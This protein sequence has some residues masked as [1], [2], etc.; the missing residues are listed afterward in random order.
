MNRFTSRSG[1][2]AWT[3]LVLVSALSMFAFGPANAQSVGDKT[4]A[5]I[6]VTASRLEQAQTD[7]L[8]HT[9]VISSEDIKN[10]GVRDLPSLLQ[11]EAGI[12]FTQPGG[13][14]QPASLFMRGATPGETLILIDGVPVRREGFSAA[15]ALEHILPDQIDR[16]EIVRGNV[17]A[18]YGS[19]AIGG[20][21]QIFTKQGAGTPTAS[22]SAEIGSRG[23]R[24]VTGG[25]SG[26]SGNTRYALSATSFRTD[27]VSANNT[28]QYPNENPDDDGY[29]NKS[30]AASLSNEWTKG[31][32]LG[33]RLY[34]N[35]GKFEYDGGGFGQ[36]T[37]IDT[38]RSKQRSAAVFSKNRLAPQWLSTLTLSKTETRTE[39]I[40]IS[41]FGSTTRDKGDTSLLQWANEIGLSDGWTL[42]T[43]VDTGRQELDTFSAS[44]FGITEN[45]FDRS[46]ASAFVGA[47]GKV[48]LHQ[49]QLNARQDYV[50][51]S[52]SDTT[53]FVGYGFAI[54]PAIKLIANAST[55]FNAPTLAQVY[56]PSFGNPDLKA[57]RSRSYEVG[58]Q[59]AVT[60]SLLRATLF[61]TRT[62]DQFGFGPGFKTVNIDKAR[63]QGLELSG[64]TRLADLDMRASLT[65]QDP[66]DANTGERLIRRAKRL[67]TLSLSKPFDR[68]RIGTDIQYTGSR[69]DTD[70]VTGNDVELKSFWLVN[71][72]ARYQ[73][74]NNVSI[75]GRLENAFDR[76]YQTAYGYN[77]T[78][79]SLFV[80]VNWQL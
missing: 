30:I 73:V 66:E 19:G 75:Y 22:L 69:R 21:I 62:R 11:R 77:Q 8:P 2:A 39:N 41:A 16:I 54:T 32:E 5:P 3:P 71:L 35:D 61:N 23:T 6:V 26:K 72:N 33:I 59:Y 78:P 1:M 27:G 24:A 65:V 10:S 46:V 55:A 52:G 80:G 37:D 38:G 15:A 58:A 70:F 64:T 12:Q 74:A 50:E 44:S 79:R 68:F 36:P 76:E 31:H 18:I 49:F 67:G 25:V 13:L 14:G 4:L 40:S 47:N 48:G 60:G 34:A 43:G 20:V 57:E 7:A 51:G 29:R 63:N 28:T 53:G 56:D 42:V 17:S 45:S 9:T